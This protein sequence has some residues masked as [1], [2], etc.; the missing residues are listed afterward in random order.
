MEHV[1]RVDVLETTQNLVEEVADVVVRQLLCLQ[2]FVKIGLHKALDD[3]TERRT[4][5][6]GEFGGQLT[7]PSSNRQF[8][9]E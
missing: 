8:R 7:C 5:L 9:S 3:V 1:S 2:Q 6:N 4:G